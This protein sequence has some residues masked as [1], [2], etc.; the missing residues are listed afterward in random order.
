MKW[1]KINFTTEK[2]IFTE[3]YSVFPTL[4]T[5]RC[6]TC[7]VVARQSEVV[8]VLNESNRGAEAYEGH[9]GAIKIPL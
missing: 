9:E 5:A 3:F 8:S 6:K 7:R 1:L 4:M 2:T